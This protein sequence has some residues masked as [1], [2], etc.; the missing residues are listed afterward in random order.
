MGPGQEDVAS[1]RGPLDVE[2]EGLYPVSWPEDLSWDRFLHIEDGVGLSEIDYVMILFHALNNACYNFTLLVD[3]FVINYVTF[4]VPDLLEDDLLRCLCSY[5]AERR[6]IH[7]DADT[8]AGHR[9]GIDIRRF[10]NGNLRISLMHLI[11]D[12]LKLVDFHL[13]DLF[14]VVG[15]KGK[16]GSESLFCRS[17][18]GFF[19]SSDNRLLRDTLFFSHLLNDVI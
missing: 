6:C 7:L 12:R 3:V 10:L 9:F 1:F 18:E 13:A 16:M 14:A 8:V 17:E 11:N 19:D 15:F 5:P 2:N 4:G